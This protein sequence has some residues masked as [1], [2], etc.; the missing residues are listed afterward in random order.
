ML[1]HLL[2]AALRIHAI[3]QPHLVRPFMEHAVV[4]LRADGTSVGSADLFIYV[5]PQPALFQAINV[6][7]HDLRYPDLHTGNRPGALQLAAR[8]TRLRRLASTVQDTADC[9]TRYIQFIPYFLQ[10]H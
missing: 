1:V 6:D 5:F 4:V 3:H 8:T 10:T 9:G 7:G 2:R